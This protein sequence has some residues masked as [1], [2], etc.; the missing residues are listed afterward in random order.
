MEEK[1]IKMRRVT[2]KSDMSNQNNLTILQ[3]DDGDIVISTYIRDEYDSG[4]EICTSQGGSRLKNNS[5]IIKHFM[6]II[7]LL[8]DEDDTLVR[9]MNQ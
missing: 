1:E 6:A 8:M 5:E 2:V 4:V 3:Q 7:D 9:K